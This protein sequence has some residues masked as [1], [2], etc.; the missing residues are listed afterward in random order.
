[1][2]YDRERNTA[3]CRRYQRK[4]RQR[5][6]EAYGSVCQCCGESQFEFLSL[7]HING[8][9]HEHRRQVGYG[10]SFL[11]WLNRNNFPPGLQVLCHNCNMAKGFHKECP[12]QSM[13]REVGGLA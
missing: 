10:N 2:E 12:H 4:L 13:M 3:K 7:D 11:L 1:M 6:L 8:G 9:G 5:A